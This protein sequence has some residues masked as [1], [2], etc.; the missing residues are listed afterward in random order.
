MTL[1]SVDPGVAKP[2]AFAVFENDKLIE[3]FKTNDLEHIDVSLAINNVDKLI[4]EDQ[5]L[6]LNPRTM[7]N[8]VRQSGKIM[9]VAELSNIET[10]TV[11]PVTWQSYFKIPRRPKGIKQYKWGAIHKLDLIEKAEELTGWKFTGDDDTASAVLIGL[12][13]IEND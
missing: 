12:W 1:M 5:F 6:G 9:G 11:M 13:S 4:M 10:S 8:L 7:K 3:T 2:S